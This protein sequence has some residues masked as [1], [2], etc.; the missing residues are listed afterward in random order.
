MI[1]DMAQHYNEGPIQLGDI[2]KR[3][4]ISLKYLYKLS[5]IELKS[6]GLKLDKTSLPL[7]RWVLIV[8]LGFRKSYLSRLMTP[9]SAIESRPSQ[10]L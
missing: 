2:A 8:F 10:W 4:E 7:I 3:Q 9:T 1:L 6:R 5:L